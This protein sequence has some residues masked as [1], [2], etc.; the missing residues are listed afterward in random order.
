MTSSY[1]A[2]LALLR[3][4]RVHPVGR[5]RGSETRSGT[6]HI[7]S[8]LFAMILALQAEGSSQPFAIEIG[9]LHSPPR[10]ARYTVCKLSVQRKRVA[11]PRHGKTVFIPIGGKCWDHRRGERSEQLRKASQACNSAVVGTADGCCKRTLSSCPVTRS[12]F[13]PLVLQPRERSALTGVRTRAVAC[14]PCSALISPVPRA[15]LRNCRV[16]TT[17]SQASMEGGQ[18]RSLTRRCRLR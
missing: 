13:S 4:D 17:T 10:R 11:A 8:R 9:A 7:H 14:A 12:S 16:L 3:G 5:I 1:A 2:V 18:S 6:R 15:K